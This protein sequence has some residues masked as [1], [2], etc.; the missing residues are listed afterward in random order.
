MRC[1]HGLYPDLAEFMASLDP[2]DPI[3][4]AGDF[5]GYGSTN[6]CSLTGQLAA[7]RLVAATR[8]ARTGAMA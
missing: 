8:F 4:L 1:E 2:A 5:F 6:R 7:R 3:Q